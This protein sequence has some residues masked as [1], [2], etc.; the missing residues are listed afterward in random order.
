M[1]NFDLEKMI[2]RYRQ[3]MVGMMG[4]A[5]Q[6]ETAPK[7]EEKK[8]EDKELVE[9]IAENLLESKEEAEEAIAE[10]EEEAVPVN[11]DIN[12]V[13]KLLSQAEFEERNTAKGALK[14]QAS[15]ARQAFPVADV[16]VSI[17][18][19]FSDNMKVYYSVTTDN[20]GIVDSLVLPAPPR[21]LS[22][23]PE[24]EKP[25]ASYT[26]VAKHPDYREETISDVQV[27]DSIKSILKL[28]MKPNIAE[29]GGE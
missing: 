10:V 6:E 9:D 1:D 26:V 23:T 2:S 3:E 17:Y 22:Q 20:N 15:T 29:M 5:P 11:V 19:Q 21:A 7:V 14:V 12:L 16:N 24:S 27:F 8:N 18:K 25:F 4:S 13:E 28:D